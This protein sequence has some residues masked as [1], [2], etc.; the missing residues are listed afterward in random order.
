MKKKIQIETAADG[1][2]VPFLSGEE[3]HVCLGSRYDGT[4]AHFFLE[5]YDWSQV[6]NVILF[7]MGDA[8]IIRE[9]RRRISGRV[10]VYE[11]CHELRSLML[12]Q[13]GYLTQTERLE[14]LSDQWETAVAVKT[15]LDEDAVECTM[16]LA[17]PQ[18]TA[19]FP[20][21]A[22]WLN[23]FVQ[24][25]CDDIGGLKLS[26]QRFYETMLQNRIQNIPLMKD[27]FFLRRLAEYFDSEIP[28]LLVSAGPSLRKNIEGV[29]RMKGK[30]LVF[31]VDAVLP[32]LLS[33]D[34]LPDLIITMESSKPLAFFADKR[35]TKIPM[36]VMNNS[37]YRIIKEHEAE[38]IWVQEH[39]PY[40]DG[41]LQSAGVSLSEIEFSAGVATAALAV[42]LEL[43]TK[44]IIFAGQDLAYGAD[45][46]THVV[47]REE[48]F[49]ED[50]QYIVDGYYGD[51]VQSR[52]DWC[53]FRQYFEE[54][55]AAYPDRKFINA[56][57]GGA[58]IKGAECMP[59]AEVADSLPDRPYDMKAIL[60][61]AVQ[62]KI[63]KKQFETVLC[64]FKQSYEDIRYIRKL[65]YDRFFFE[66][67]YRKILVWRLIVS[68]MR[69]LN[70]AAR[71]ERFDRAVALVEREMDNF[72][73]EWRED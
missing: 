49:I 65:G 60:A 9:I 28:I 69:G 35:Y 25:V 20:K 22:E 24:K 48:G 53:V 5:Q 23:T 31:A 33:Q 18:Y 40:V 12:W 52:Y 58:M 17:H 15:M 73:A 10:I 44:T 7:G 8:T 26:V 59:L 4:M 56:T 72:W 51:K 68:A 61:K 62:A 54:K 50:A 16:L 27:G 14:V 34:I 66:T 39:H 70:D 19:F 13:D 71:R 45:G 57:E 6:E 63:T 37:N 42:S 30:A 41:L 64:G 46:V 47:N 3:T 32:Y 2:L 29:R 11:P 36:V 55:I 1:H 21:E 67:E 43:G 38:K